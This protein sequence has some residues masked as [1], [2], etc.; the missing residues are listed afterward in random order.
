MYAPVGSF[1]LNVIQSNG[2]LTLV[3][4]STL[5]SLRQPHRAGHK[6]HFRLLCHLPH[7]D[8][9]I[10][11]VLS[12]FRCNSRDTSRPTRHT[13]LECVDLAL[14]ER[15]GSRTQLVSID[16][17]CVIGA[18]HRQITTV[19]VCFIPLNEDFCFGNM[20]DSRGLKQ[21]MRIASWKG[22]SSVLSQDCRL[23]EHP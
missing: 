8:V 14:L 23:C 22:D 17:D 19:H 6:V 4:E 18:E 5:L 3:L 10:C 7:V 16:L 1:S 13:W 12:G 20:D 9:L 11:K 21:T 15:G 2:L